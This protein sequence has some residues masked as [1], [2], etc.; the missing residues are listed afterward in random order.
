MTSKFKD[1]SSFEPK[2]E[3]YR[4]LPFNFTQFDDE[5]YIATNMVGEYVLLK[6]QSLRQFVS[7]ELEKT[8]PEYQEL[9]SRHFLYDDP[10]SSAFELLELK[11]RTRYQHLPQFTGLHIF[12]VTLRCEHSCP[13]CQVSRQ[14]EDTETF[15]MSVETSNKALEFVFRSPSQNIKIEF[16]GGE[17]LLNFSLIRHIVLK[18]EAINQTEKRNLGFVASTNLAVVTEEILSFC[19]DHK[20]DISTS[21]DGPKAIHN[22]NRPRQGRDSYE[23]AVAGITLARDIVGRYS[24]SALMTTTAASIESVTEIIDEY[25][26]LGFNGIFL[27]KLSPYGFAVKT[28]AITGYTTDEWFE[29]YKKGLEHIIEL[30]RRGIEFREFFSSVVLKKMLTSLDSGF[31]DL[32]S[33]AGIGIKVIVY[34]YDGDIYASDE[35]RMLAE[36]GDTTFNLGNIHSLSYKDVFTSPALLDPIEQS[37]AISAPMCNECAFE[38][39]CGADPIYHYTVYGDYLGRKPESSF[40][41]RNMSIFRLLITMMRDDKYVENLFHKWANG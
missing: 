25:V 1:I 15:D 3:G 22:K 23:R 38:P 9:K 29:F 30:N 13:Y 14:T 33:P 34:N 10:N 32:M 41:Q 16:Q 37:I 18:A 6:E 11:A 28:S 26:S 21:L 31:V 17:S 35:S 2:S 40:C 36:M 4:L 24:V 5:S 19:R 27:R 12:V 20:I 39:Y 8:A 7:H